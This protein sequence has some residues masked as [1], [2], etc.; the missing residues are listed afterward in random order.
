MNLMFDLM[1]E[2]DEKSVDHQRYYS[3]SRGAPQQLLRLIRNPRS[4]PPGG[5][6]TKVGG[7]AEF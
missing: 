3:L 4:R 1:M 2:K 5:A 6:R 7:S